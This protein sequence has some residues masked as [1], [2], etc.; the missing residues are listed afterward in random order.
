MENMIYLAKRK[1]GTLSVHA[2]K[3]AMYEMDG[4]EPEMT[5]T[6]AEYEAAEG[7]VR[8]IKGKFVLGK[9]EAEKAEEK[10]QADIAKYK[11]ELAELD[12]QVGSGRSIRDISMR[13][14]EKNGMTNDDAYATLKEIE[15][16]ADE[17]RKVLKP[18]LTN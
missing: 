18:L 9:T 2:D 15:E 5:V 8:I 4:L 1:D 7:I 14:A 10:K 6:A 12:K 11:A 16:S 3:N 17:I 13:L